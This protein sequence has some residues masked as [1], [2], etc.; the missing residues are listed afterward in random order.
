MPVRGVPRLASA[1]GESLV[2]LV[3]RIAVVAAL[4]FARGCS[5]AGGDADVVA[6]WEGGGGPAR[7]GKVVV[8]DVPR[9]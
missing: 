8:T 7:Y 1:V 4:V 9:S 3:V 6:E 2:R 5:G